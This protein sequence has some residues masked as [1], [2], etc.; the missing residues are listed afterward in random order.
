MTEHY[1]TPKPTSKMELNLINAYLRGRYF[2]FWTSSSVFSKRRIDP[3]TR[4]LIE[5]MILPE[6]G[7]VL[8]IGCGYGAIGIA[9]AALNPNIYVIML[10]VN[11]R[12]IWLAKRNIKL[13]G[14][15]NAE[16]RRGNL[17][18]PVKGMLFNCILSNPPISAGMATV[19]AIIT[20]APEHMCEGATFQMVVKSKIGRER[21]RD[22][23]ERTFG[24]F[25][26]L[27]RE[28]GYRVLMARKGR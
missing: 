13:N 24:N 19:E 28:G 18:E 16:V 21:F 4:L 5:N 22:I 14:I 25:T 15:A 23:F 17:Y 9:A 26:V 12:A 20:G 11:E 7:L 6:K 27:A 2:R 3:G 10:D 8:D 1:F